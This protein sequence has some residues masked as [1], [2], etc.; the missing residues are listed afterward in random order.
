VQWAVKSSTPF[1]TKSGGNSEW[2]TIDSE[3]VVIDLS[4]YSGI[5]VD[6]IAQIATL[7]GSVLSKEV[8]VRLA[9]AGMCT[10]MRV[11]FLSFLSE[12]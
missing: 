5:E 8:A 6:A 11:E 10:G 12:H 3:G 9:E 7:K 2:S 4:R 1:V